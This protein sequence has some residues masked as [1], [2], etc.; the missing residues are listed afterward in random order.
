M[1]VSTVTS[2]DNQGHPYRRTAFITTLLMGTFSMSI[3]QSSLSTA[4]PTLMRTF[5]IGAS[6]VQWMTTGF[7]LVMSIM[8][9]VSPWLL[10]NVRFSTLFRAV[11][12]LFALGTLLCLVA[13]TYPLLVA[14]RLIEALG[15]GIIFPSFQTVLLTITPEAQRGSTMGTA[16][17][18]MGS[19]LATG[20]VV[21]GIMLQ[22]TSWRGL[23]ALFLI[24]VGGVFVASFWFIKDV[25]PKHVTSIDGWSIGLSLGFI[26]LLFGLNQLGTNGVSNFEL[27]LL[28]VSGLAII[29]FCYRQ[30]RHTQPL[31]EL[32][33]F[34][35]RLFTIGVLLT[36]ISY[37]ALIVTTIVLPLFYQN[38]LGLSAFASGLALVPAAIGLSLLNPWAG[39]LMDRFGPRLVILIGMSL[40]MFGFGYLTLAS[41]HLTLITVILASLVTEGGNAFVMM[42]AVTLGAN[43]LPDTLIAHGTAVTTTA[44]Q[45]LGSAG[46]AGATLILSRVTTA[47]QTRLGF[48]QASLAG[49][50]A[51]FATFLFI[52]GI[53]L[54]LALTLPHGRPTKA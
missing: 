37:I 41:Q 39:K 31:L 12:G 46:V 27:G 15:V 36:G 14:G 29:G 28:V 5:G 32:R 22:L 49:Y 7:M 1:T 50:Q 54:L 6:A 2:I 44:R 11:T 20:P 48:H 8:I 13:P 4:Y 34:K 43:S 45:L 33:V 3:S 40:I 10:N 52:G 38:V 19:A 9:P 42:P 47:N 26:G 24:L 25:M 35:S 21:S 51:T 16:G 17:L 18:I 23:F 53:G 30:F